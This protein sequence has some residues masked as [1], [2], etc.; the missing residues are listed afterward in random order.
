V[1]LIFVPS[2]AEMG[3]LIFDQLRMPSTDVAAA[4]GCRSVGDI[5]LLIIMPGDLGSTKALRAFMPLLGTRPAL[6]ETRLRFL[7]LS[8]YA[9][10][11]LCGYLA[12]WLCWRCGLLAKAT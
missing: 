5:A 4:S 2:I 7:R 3:P 11:W 8:G 6:K 1:A 12:I 9:A 10:I